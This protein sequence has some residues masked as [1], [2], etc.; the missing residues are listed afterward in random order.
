MQGVR[1]I[2]GLHEAAEI[3]V[4]RWGV[5]HIRANNLHD[6]FLAQGFNAAR[7]RLWQIDLWRK[8]GLGL[9]S[10]ELGPGFLEQDRASRVMLYRGDMAAEWAAYADDAEEICTAFVA[11]INAYVGLT[12]E[13]PDLLPPEF[14]V[15]GMRPA[16]WQPQDV[17]RIRSHGLIRNA[18]SEV[19]RANVQSRAGA[20]ADLLRKKIEPERLAAIPDG[21]DLAAI[22]MAVLDVFKLAVAPATLT[23]ERCSA[24]LEQAAQWRRIGDLGDVIRDIAAE[25]SNNWTISGALTDTGR[26]VL[27]NDPHRLHALPGLR[28]LVHLTA[29]GFDAIGAGEPSAPGISLGHNGT[30]AFGL[31]IFGADQEDI[32]VYE[33]NPDDPAAYRYSDG[34]ESMQTIEETVPVRGHPDQPCV[35]RFTRHGPVLFENP[36]NRRAFALRSVWFEPGAAPYMASLTTMRARD[37]EGFRAGVRRWGTPSVNL[38]YAD[39]GGTIGWFPAGKVPVRPTA[40]GLLPI[41]GDGRHEWNGFLDPDLAPHSI[42]P[43]EGYVA[44]ANEMN[45]PDGWDQSSRQIG[46]EWLERSRSTRIHEVLGATRPLGVAVSRA[47]QTD[48]TSV[49]ARRLGRLAAALDPIGPDLAAAVALLRGFD[50]HL[51][52]DSAAAA[53][54][55]VWWTRHLRKALFALVVD[56]EDAR[57]LL[58]PGDSDTILPV[59]EGT[60]PGF[61]LDTPQARMRLLGDTL[62]ASWRECTALLGADPD[63][64]AWGRLHHALFEHPLRDFPGAEALPDVGPLPVGGSSYSPMHTGYRPGDFRVTM[65]ASVRVVV[66]VGGWDASVWINAPGQSGDP[67]SA[68]YADLA[69]VWAAGDYVPMLYSRSSVEPEIVSR[70]MLVP[71]DAPTDQ[72]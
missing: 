51:A 64:W 29:P 67:R 13:E 45:L 21:L 33:T 43:P 49:V 16:R 56:D 66:D 35:M 47:L 14:A 32:C 17:V 2:A 57:A 18:L 28:Y 59:L 24:T 48:A 19:L 3:A 31:T 22:P 12:E 36:A 71:A 9:L 58:P 11:G 52:P 20:K 27:A 8:R 69:R 55:E 46:H 44:T 39:T 41:P 50:G 72:V 63:G 40:D 5:P 42:N 61:G 53:L 7:D 23:P 30:C 62:A 38:V 34:W 15:A 60:L 54:V 26:P 25:G 70:L 65:G 68:H 4:D 1:R 37:V 6:L 10:A